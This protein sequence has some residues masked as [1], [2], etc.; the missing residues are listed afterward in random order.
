MFGQLIVNGIGTGLIVALPAI[1]LTLTFRILRFPNF[2]IGAMLTFAA[3]LAWVLNTIAGI[4][5]M[6]SA[7]LTVI[8]FPLVVLLCD[9]AV[10]RPLRDR[11][12]ITLLVASM[13]LSFVL[14][15]LCRLFFGNDARNFDIPL[16]RPHRIMDLRIN[17]ELLVT[18][19]VSVGGMVLVYFILKHTPLGRAMR[20]VADNPNLAAA[21][22]INGEKVVQATW[23]LAGTLVAAS[24]ILI[25]MDRA[26]DPQM[27][28][29]YIIICFAA[30]ILGGLGSPV[31]AVVGA[32]LLGVVGELATL[33][34]APN[35]RAAVAFAAIA[36][37]LLMRPN[38]LF[39]TP[40][41]VK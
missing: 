33:V 13:G 38:G 37:V 9:A 8:L 17:N 4:P 39:G 35:Y 27:G 11:G 5:L 23:A 26:I 2:A 32:L 15:N 30:A 3:Y 7:V 12:S 40:E 34:V 14:E 36:L 21:R 10:F 19:G 25:G 22:G 6:A 29:N 18:A 1:A 31:G 41:I 24:G 28:W 20:A 16:S